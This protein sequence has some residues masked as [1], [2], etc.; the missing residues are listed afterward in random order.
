MAT[1]YF[2]QSMFEARPELMSVF[3]CVHVFLSLL[4]SDFINVFSRKCLLSAYLHNDA[5]NYYSTQVPYARKTFIRECD[6][7][8]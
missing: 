8:G 1:P 6:F 5:Q 3:M 2:C 4:I 7:S